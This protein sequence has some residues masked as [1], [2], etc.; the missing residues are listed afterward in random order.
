MKH[1]MCNLE[2]SEAIT[3]SN[4][5]HRTQY[6]DYSTQILSDSPLCYWRL[7]ERQGSRVAVNLGS[8][9]SSM[10]GYYS[11]VIVLAKSLEMLLIIYHVDR[12]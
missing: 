7:T 1:N 10:S 12:M 9:G 11:E 3:L 2:L 6:L 8:G 4:R 5:A